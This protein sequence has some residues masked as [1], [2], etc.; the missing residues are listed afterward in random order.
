MIFIVNFPT[1]EDIYPI[2][3]LRHVYQFNFTSDK[4]C[5]VLCTAVNSKY[6]PRKF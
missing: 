2:S 1:T 5:S 4:P 3:A 6:V